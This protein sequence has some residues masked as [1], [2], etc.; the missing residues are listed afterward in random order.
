MEFIIYGRNYYYQK[1]LM[2]NYTWELIK[3]YSKVKVKGTGN[4][5]VFLLNKKSFSILPRSRKCGPTNDILNFVKNNYFFRKI[6][7]F[8]LQIVLCPEKSLLLMANVKNKLVLLITD[9]VFSLRSML[10]P[11]YIE[12]VS[13]WHCFAIIQ[14]ETTCSSSIWNAFSV[15]ASMNNE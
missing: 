12:K 5:I 14:P 8:V 2:M 10:S 9:Q 4:I 15:W 13:G 3:R 7:S 1:L 6:I 11:T